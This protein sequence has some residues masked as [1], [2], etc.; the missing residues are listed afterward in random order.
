MFSR[1]T[2]IA[3][4]AVASAAF[5]AGAARA[6][7]ACE[8]FTADRQKATTPEAAM[9]MLKDGN[10]RF[11]AGKSVNCD[12]MAQVK[13][14]GKGQA[15]FAAVVG[16]IDSRGSPELI[17]DQHIG[18]IFSARIA[19]NF[20]NDDIIGSLEFA[21][22]VAGAKAIVVLGHSECGAVKGAIDGAQLGLL[23]QFLDKIKPSMEGI[24]PAGSEKTS[25]NK[26]YVQSV[27]DKNAQLAAKA[28]VER[29]AV[30][31]EL[32]DT[33]QLVVASAMLDVGTGEVRFF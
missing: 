2:F 32:V 14:T 22:K 25:K 16:C 29:S 5:T 17:F 31:K 8:I 23:T 18:D 19:G 15:P 21:T 33:K 20:V 9:Q 30:I 28:L 6:E 10:A 4:T 27:A 26:S 12:L 3:G 13:Y 24:D 7:D 11:V 1:R